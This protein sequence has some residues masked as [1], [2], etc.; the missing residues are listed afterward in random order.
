MGKEDVFE[1]IRIPLSLVT[2][3]DFAKFVKIGTRSLF[4]D[5][6]NDVYISFINSAMYL[7]EYLTRYYGLIGSKLAD[8]LETLYAKEEKVKTRTL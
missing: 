6:P 3:K 8:D 7:V 2:S 5:Y 1:W 4:I